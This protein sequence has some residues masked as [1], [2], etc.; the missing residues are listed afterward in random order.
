MWPKRQ[1]MCKFPS[2]CHKY[3]SCQL[4]LHLFLWKIHFNSLWTFH[5]ENKNFKI[6]NISSILASYWAPKGTSSFIWTNRNPHYL[7]WCLPNLAET[8]PAIL[9]K[10]SWTGSL[11]PHVDSCPFSIFVRNL[12]FMSAAF[13]ICPSIY[14]RFDICPQLSI[15]VR[16]VWF[17]SVDLSPIWCMS[18]DFDICPQSLPNVRQF[19]CQKPGCLWQI[20]LVF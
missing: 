2:P 13:D 11:C 16:S 3:V 17:M 14:V 15:N 4:L 18:A 10:K 20:F 12:R 1:C 19:L 5:H 9:E 7:K 6:L 8:N